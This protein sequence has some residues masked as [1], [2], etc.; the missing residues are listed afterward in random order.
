M[1]IEDGGEKQNL[2]P[3]IKSS[4]NLQ[5]PPTNE[6]RLEPI[7]KAKCI[8]LKK[9]PQLSKFSSLNFGSSPLGSLPRIKTKDK[10][11]IIKKM[12]ELKS[13]HRLEVN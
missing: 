6:L 5:T 4:L 13:K 8:K 7:L 2:F 1:N 9:I 11:V 12:K 10:S 3:Q